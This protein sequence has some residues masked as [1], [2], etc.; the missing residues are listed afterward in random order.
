MLLQ[1]NKM[2]RNKASDDAGLVIEMVQHGSDALLQTILDISNDIIKRVP[3]APQVWRESTVRV[4]Y[5]K[6]DARQL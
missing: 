4:L 6:G 5:K 2:A 3:Q 1:L